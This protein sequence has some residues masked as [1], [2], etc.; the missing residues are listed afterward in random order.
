[1]ELILLEQFLEATLARTSAGVRYHRPRDLAAAVVL[2]EDHLAVHRETREGKRAA[3]A[4]ERPVPAPQ[5]E[6]CPP[7]PRRHKINSSFSSASQALTCPVPAPR[8]L[9][10]PLAE[11]G[12]P[13]PRPRTTDFSFISSASQVQ[14][15][16]DD[17]LPPQT[18]P[19]TPGQACWRCGQRDHVCQKSPRMEVGQ[20]I[21]VVGPLAPSPGPGETYC[22][23]EVWQ[24]AFVMTASCL[25]TDGEK[26]WRREAECHQH[27]AMFPPFEAWPVAPHLPL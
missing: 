24:Q 5:A 11:A 18:A 1:M 20:V 25:T 9:C 10:A 21:R 19:Q 2:A 7:G 27:V 4:A 17:V 12:L 23:P 14:A 16:T 8:R 6:A 3:E 22:V 26:R 15:A 13:V